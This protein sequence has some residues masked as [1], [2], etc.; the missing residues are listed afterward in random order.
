MLTAPQSRSTSLYS[1]VLVNGADDAS[2]LYLILCQSKELR[3]SVGN[4][5][6]TQ[7]RQE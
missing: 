1:H 7:S 3:G 5:N 6:P 2:V 4:R